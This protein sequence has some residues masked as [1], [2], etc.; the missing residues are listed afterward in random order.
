MERNNKHENNRLESS[1]D[2]FTLRQAGRH[3]MEVLSCLS[4]DKVIAIIHWDD[5]Q[6]IGAMGKNRKNS[7]I[8]QFHDAKSHKKSVADCT[9]EVNLTSSLS[10]TSRPS[11]KL[12]RIL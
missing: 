11:L 3:E 6:V 5:G 4:P 7:K 2:L 1:F 9:L 8:L 10:A 12:I